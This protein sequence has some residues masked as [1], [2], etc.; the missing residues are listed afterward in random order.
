MK[1]DVFNINNFNVIEDKENYYV[2]RALNNADH[3]DI[4][5]ESIDDKNNIKRIRTDRERFEEKSGKTPKYSSESDISLEEVW[6]HVKIKYLKQT[7]C[8]SLSSNTNVI[9]D[10]GQSYNEEYVMLKVSKQNDNQSIYPAG[11]YMLDEVD[12]HIE[13]T[14]LTISEDSV[15]LEKIKEIDYKQTYNDINSLVSDEYDRL[16]KLEDKNDNQIIT[17]S[18]SAFRL[19]KKQYF[20]DEQQLEYNKSIAKLTMLE[21]NGHLKSI[22][23]GKSNNTSLI[24]T[25]GN[26]FSSGELIHY[27]DI[28]ADEM[29]KVSKEMMNMFSL[30]QQLKDKDI[31]DESLKLLEKQL[32][33]TVNNSSED[34]IKINESKYEKIENKDE[35][36]IGE[37][38]KITS[39]KVSYEKAKI[40]INLAVKGSSSRLEAAKYA[41]L[42][43][44][45]IGESTDLVDTIKEE[46]F[47]VDKDIISREN[48]IGLKIAESVNIGVTQKEKAFISNSEQINLIE[49][50]KQLDSDALE[51][52]LE[53]NGL[54]IKNDILENI[55]EQGK[56]ISEN[57]YFAEAIID[58]IDFGKIYDTITDERRIVSGDERQLLIN[59]LTNVDN[60]LLYNSFTKAGVN[61]NYVSGYIVN[62]LMDNGYKGHTIEELSQLDNLDEIISKNIKNLNSR[63]QP[64]RLDKLLNI[65]DDAHSVSNTEIKLRDYQYDTLQNMKNIFE[66]KRFASMIL[67]TGAGKSFVTM[68]E[69]MNFQNSNIIFVAPQTTILSQFQNHIVNHV[70]NK[71]NTPIKERSKLIEEA[72]PHLKMYCYDT[73]ASQD[74]EWLNRLDADFIVLDELHRAGAKTWQ[75]QIKKLLDNNPSAKVLGMTATPIRDMDGKDMTRELAE[76][77][78]E[79]TAK[80]LIQKEHLASEM[81][82][83]DAMQDDIVVSPKVVTF[84]Y[85]LGETQEYQ[86]MKKMIN[87]EKDPTKKEELKKVYKE[88]TAIIKNS[89]KDGIN[90]IFAD[91]MKKKNGKYIVF[92]PNN[93][94]E[95]SSEDYMQK[96]IENVKK[97]FTEI[98]PN[99]KTSYLLSDR[100][101]P[102]KE[103]MKALQEFENSNSD[104]LKLIF[105]INMLNEG[106]HVDDIDGAVMLRPISENSKILYLQQIGRCI[107]SLDPNKPISDDDRPV[108][109]DVYNNYLAQNMDRE[110]NKT[111]TTS[112]LQRLQYT[113][114]WIDKHK[115][116]MPDINSEDDKEARKA[117]TLKNIQ[118]K[119]SRYIDVINN[120]NLSESELY[121]IE[122]IIELGRKIELWDL[123]IPERIK[124]S[125]QK[126]I[127]RNNVFKVSGTQ[128]EFMDLFKKAERMTINRDLSEELR[129]KNIMPVLSTLSE[130]GIEISNEIIKSNSTWSDVLENIS[131]DVRIEILEQIDLESNYKIGEEYEHAKINFF[132]GNKKFT[133]YDIG[134]LR[135]CGMF[136][137]LENS[138]M[139]SYLERPGKRKE[140]THKSY[141][142]EDGFIKYG[143]KEFI[144]LNINTGTIYDEE[145][146]KSNGYDDHLFKKGDGDIVNKYGFGRNLHCYK[147]L[148]DGTLI[149]TN[150]FEDDHGFKF[151]GTWEETDKYL[152]KDN[153]DIHGDYFDR[154][155]NKKS[156]NKRDY[157]GFDI[158]G[159]D[160]YGFD[161]DGYFYKEQEDGKYTKTDIIKS[162]VLISMIKGDRKW[163]EEG[164]DIYNIN[165][166]GFSRNSEDRN[167]YKKQENEKYIRTELEFAP[168]GR[169]YYNI[170]KLGFDKNGIY[171]ERQEDGT[172]VNTNQEFAPDGYNRY[173]I[174]K[175]GFSRN[176]DDVD[177]YLKKADGTYRKTDKILST[178]G[179]D[180]NYK[181]DQGFTKNKNTGEISKYG[182][183]VEGIYHKEQEDGTYKNTGIKYNEFGFKADNRHCATKMA[184][185]IRGFDINGKCKKNGD[186]TYDENGFKQDGTYMETGEKYY[187]GYNAYGVDEDGKD[188]KG[189]VHNDITF[190]QDYIDAVIQGKR[191]EFIQKSFEINESN[192]NFIMHQIDMKV[193][194]AAEMYPKVKQK[195]LMNVIYIQ[196]NVKKREAMLEELHSKN[197]NNP[198]V[199]KLEK[200]ITVFKNRMSSIDLSER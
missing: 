72:F 75:P 13:Q 25:I 175:R 104:E 121:E 2:F 5:N 80:E 8:I 58:G 62:F 198:E 125:N 111:N 33:E 48:S 87:E 61:P 28:N 50:I 132:K 55:L 46:C 187:K 57:Q 24:A 85:N 4:E 21:M 109:F 26:A 119:Y 39:G 136:E 179:Y 144:G 108:I 142:V 1:N 183:D 31:Y 190:T 164:Y 53:S 152:N 69:M 168:D 194:T 174:D 92:L 42:V 100:L 67:P 54:N 73:I 77:I 70:L 157:A 118:K 64:L 103:N 130:Y 45:F 123:E 36:S 102:K 40:A 56:D 17:K 127:S 27:K 167:Y 151:D 94:T 153:F 52:I 16:K 79:Y 101:D 137:K 78:G 181:D 18:G 82:L 188:Q 97:Y 154:D 81:Y 148:A 135:E 43:N 139:V 34:L 160:I 110:V 184:I 178:D 129:L 7:N 158:N 10:Y 65:E 41:N 116:Y 133:N 196:R 120:K 29:T 93:N 96:E 84:D 161:K 106:V 51:K 89:E 32:I 173:D 150:S 171:Y 193:Y 122:N 131:K 47:I 15:L 146:Y 91:N 60:K 44:D 165:K 6:D 112:D 134:E 177:F 11:K 20:S 126:D 90:K 38:Y 19:N 105:S 169:N 185:D 200:E 23:S 37:I 66:D 83:L 128:K 22:L 9:I 186:S 88:M 145:G 156:R 147:K 74:D 143:P 163:D 170:D 197:I 76:I 59:K 189:N 180:K 192:K 115:G 138:Q 12:K 3:N 166:R 172:Y 63:I 191:N 98:N 141:S 49:K 99:I 68:A 107:Y 113:I 95:L 35:L 195:V 117:I 149:D 182:F 30:V 114:N 71:K 199:A 155:T 124:A 162:K 14:L 86:E 140:Y 176:E 159:L